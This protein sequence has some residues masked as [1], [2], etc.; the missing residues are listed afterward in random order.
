MTVINHHLLIQNVVSKKYRFRFGQPLSKKYRFRFGLPLALWTIVAWVIFLNKA[1]MDPW[2][3]E[4]Y[5]HFQILMGIWLVVA[6]VLVSY[7]VL[8]ED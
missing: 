4:V 1:K 3:R 6:M 2:L 7:Y 8:F 5:P